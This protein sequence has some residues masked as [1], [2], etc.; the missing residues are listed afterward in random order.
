[1]GSR[2]ETH[3]MD[4]RPFERWCM[5]RRSTGERSLT[6]DERERLVRMR[7]GIGWSMTWPWAAF[8]AYWAILVFV[9]PDRSTDDAVRTV[10]LFFTLL[11]M[12]LLLPVAILTTR[13]QWRAFA[14]VG[15]DLRDGRVERFEP[16]A[17]GSATDPAG[18]VEVRQPSARLLTGPRREIGGPAPIRIVAPGPIVGMRVRHPAEGL[19]EG[20]RLERRH[21]SPEE[22]DELAQAIRSVEQVPL[23]VWI[24]GVWGAVSMWGW[25]ASTVP[26]SPTKFLGL[27]LG[28]LMS[29]WFVWT[30]V[31]NLTLA[32]R[33]REDIEAGFALVFVPPDPGARE[34]EGLPHSGLPWRIAG[35]PA[36]WRGADLLGSR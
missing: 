15:R 6:P 16:V 35:L 18:P 34:E 3:P 36:E 26:A 19:P 21:L 13:D 10:F 25:S 1:M 22:Q 4:P 29:G 2:D 30:I 28:V 5:D 33:M 20:A 14:D 7:R 24:G 12:L 17:T 11:G 31:R 9:V 32:R 23:R 27:A 8:L